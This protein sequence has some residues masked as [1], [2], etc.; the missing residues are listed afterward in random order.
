MQG[1]DPSMSAISAPPEP[2]LRP[3]PAQVPPH[4]LPTFS[5]TSLSSVLGQSSG[6][7][8]RSFR[9]PPSSSPYASRSS[10]VSGRPGTS[11][12]SIPSR[13]G[14]SS[15]IAVKP[16]LRPLPGL[17]DSKVSPHYLQSSMTASSALRDPTEK[18][19]ERKPIF[20]KNPIR[21][22]IPWNNRG[23][24]ASGSRTSPIGIGSDSDDEV[25]TLAGS[26]IPADL[27]K[28]SNQAAPFVIDDDEDSVSTPLDSPRSSSDS[29]AEASRLFPVFQPVSG[30]STSHDAASRVDPV[31]AVLPLS[32]RLR[33]Y[34]HEKAHLLDIVIRLPSTG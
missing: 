7:S 16:E 9:A 14:S 26:Q 30:L 29:R 5:R 24:I 23:T 3:S 4:P 33:N 18:L 19:P 13:T 34:K 11:K 17:P 22:S 32:Q 31:T 28:K 25:M 21:P 1:I 15:S 27:R 12:P 20:E 10:G 2:I 6:E 8:S